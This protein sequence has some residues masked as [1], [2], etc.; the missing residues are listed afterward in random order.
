MQSITVC[1]SR[2]MVVEVDVLV[3]VVLSVCAAATPAPTSATASTRTR[4]A[5]LSLITRLRRIGFDLVRERRKTLRCARAM[6]PGPAPRAPVRQIWRSE[7]LRR[8][9]LGLRLGDGRDPCRRLARLWRRAHTSA[10]DRVFIGPTHDRSNVAAS[11]LVLGA[12]PTLALDQLPEIDAVVVPFLPSPVL[13]V[14]R[15]RHQFSHA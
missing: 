8:S 5:I 12:H 11:D 7:G 1:S 13:R 10:G 2:G 6:L 14:D 4:D 9:G 15:S 3:V